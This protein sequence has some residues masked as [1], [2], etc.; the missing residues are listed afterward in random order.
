LLKTWPQLIFFGSTLKTSA[1]RLMQL[2]FLLCSL[3]F[4]FML[5][6]SAFALSPNDTAKGIIKTPE[7][8]G[9]RAEHASANPTSG[10]SAQ[11]LPNT[12]EIVKPEILVFSAHPTTI[13]IGQSVTLRW[14]TNHALKVA[15]LPHLGSAESPK[16]TCSI[17]PAATTTYTL[18]AFR[19]EHVTEKKITIKV[20]PPLPLISPPPPDLF[21][22]G[23][24]IVLRIPFRVNR[25]RLPHSAHDML[26]ELAEKI[27]HKRLVVE[28]VGHTDSKGSSRF[29]YRLSVQRA[30]AV[31]KYLRRRGV[32]SHRMRA[33]GVGSKEPI[34]RN[35]TKE[36]RSKNRRI[37]VKVIKVLK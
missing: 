35:K 24:Y 16:G 8:G 1:P 27:L 7:H 3:C 36:G 28:I 11:A 23:D 31:K 19:G 32:P 12:Q 29:N 22:P 21:K 5:P 30:A 34:T 25:S 17:Q 9:K 15:I 33:Y 6:H 10:T 14:E 20:Q 2:R 26:D 4:C 18:M 13:R 37:E